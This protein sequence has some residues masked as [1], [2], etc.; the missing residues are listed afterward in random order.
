MS[1][2]HLSWNAQ[3]QVKLEMKSLRLEVMFAQQV[4]L[5]PEAT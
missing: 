5:F 4:I 3:N 2:K 1:M